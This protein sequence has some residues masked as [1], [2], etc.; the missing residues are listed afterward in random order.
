MLANM[1][2]LSNRLAV[3]EISAIS[4]CIALADTESDALTLVACDILVI[5]EFTWLV[6]AVSLS[7]CLVEVDADSLANSLNTTSVLADSLAAVLANALATLLSLTLA[8]T[9]ALFAAA[10]ST[11]DSEALALATTDALTLSDVDALSL[12]TVEVLALADSSSL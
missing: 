10:E 5:S 9:L 12:I 7:L 4:E 3:I 6:T 2:S 1:L 8:A 11:N